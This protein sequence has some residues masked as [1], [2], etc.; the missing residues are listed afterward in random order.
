MATQTYEIVDARTNTL[1]ARMVEEAT[2]R[3]RSF[4]GLMLTKHL[5]SERGLL[6][7]PARG[8]HT[9][10]MRF[11]ID[12]IFLDERNR[13]VKIRSSMP[14]WR[15]APARAAA[16]IEVAAGLADAAGVRIGDEFLFRSV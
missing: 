15:I 14:P 7:R 10:F 16:V 8:I 2:G 12:L 1:V 4:R 11:P 9:H 6:I 3:W 5:P 13:V